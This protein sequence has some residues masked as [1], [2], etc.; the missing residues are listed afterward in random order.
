MKASY[1]PNITGTGSVW[2]EVNGREF[3]VEAATAKAFANSLQVAAFA[4]ANVGKPPINFMQQ[5]QSAMDLQ[6]P[7]WFITFA[8]QQ[9]LAGIAQRCIDGR[10]G[11]VAAK[12]V[13]RH[14]VATRLI[15]PLRACVHAGLATVE[16]GS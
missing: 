10:S 5:F 13:L 8:T 14:E 15:M 9:E 3:S 6:Q 7:D 12:N 11:T 1:Q 4:A 2:I 16:D